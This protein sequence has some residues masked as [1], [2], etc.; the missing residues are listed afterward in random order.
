MSTNPSPRAAR[1]RPTSWGEATTPS[2]PASCAS[3]ASASTWSMTGRGT[4]MEISVSWS[5]LVSTVM[6]MMSGGGTP[7][8][9]APA[10]AA[11]RAAFIMA[12]PPLAWT[13]MAQA[14]SLA[15]SAAALATVFGMSWYFRSRNTRWP[16]STRR[17]T[18]SGPAAVNSWLPTLT[19]PTAPRRVSA[20]AS[21]L[22]ELSTSSA[23]MTGFT[24]AIS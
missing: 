21:A 24:A 3:H 8:F 5:K 10:C 17:R 16:A 7:A 1:S 9:A 12:N 19:A 14:P 6:A 11:S 22:S 4:P 15:A 13:S 20:S 2:A 18:M 23:T